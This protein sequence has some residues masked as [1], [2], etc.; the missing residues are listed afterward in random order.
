MADVIKKARVSVIIL[1]KDKVDYLKKCI[2][3]LEK[4]NDLTE[5]EV[6]IISNNSIEEQ[7]IIY[8]DELRKKANYLIVEHDE[9]FNYAALNNFAVTFAAGEYL[10][11]LNN[12]I[13]FV[14]NNTIENLIDTLKQVDVGIV[15]AT[16]LYPDKTIQH[17][18]VNIHKQSAWQPY[19]FGKLEEL[20][21]LKENRQVTA[22]IGA[23]L[24][25]RHMDFKALQ[26]FD[27]NLRVV[28]ND[29]DLCLK[30]N[31]RGQK[32]ICSKDILV[33]HEGVSRGKKSPM[34]DIETFISIWKETLN[35]G[36]LFDISLEI[37]QKHIQ[38][39]FNQFSIEH[40]RPVYI[41]GTG[42]KGMTALNILDKWN[43]QGFI[44][45]DMKKWGKKIETYKV[46]SPSILEGVKRRPYVIIAS[47]YYYEIREQIEELGYVNKKDFY[48]LY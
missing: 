31:E 34:E 20:E 39:Y 23:C 5:D 42:Q 16:L 46:H 7:T 27:E 15:G 33:H 2:D 1:T 44:D 48:R 26:G 28:L 45:N 3:T 38:Q 10:L 36:D 21:H 24:L 43:V 19:R 30:M 13:E 9:P 8:L 41:F 4:Y 29:I 14:S 40:D 35:K 11:F 32:T 6:I 37:S 47:Y 18:G 25:I 12:D 17:V 22:V